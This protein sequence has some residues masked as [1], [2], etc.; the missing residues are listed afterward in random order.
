MFSLLE[1]VFIEVHNRL[2]RHDS[3]SPLQGF[4]LGRLVID[5]RVTDRW[6]YIPLHILEAGCFSLGVPGV[7]KTSL[8]KHVLVEGVHR[9]WGL[10]V[11]IAHSDVLPFFLG[12]VA[13][14]ERRRGRDLS[15]NMCLFNLPDREYA[16][17]LNF[18][19]A[20]DQHEL[21]VLAAE[22]AE[23]IRVRF[24]LDSLGVRI[25]EL[26]R[27]AVFVLAATGNT[28]V[29]FRL[30]LN[31]G[32]YREGL[33]RHINNPE[34]L[35]YFREHYDRLSVAEQAMYSAAVLNKIGDLVADP[36]IAD[37]IGQRRS[38][39]SL[40]H[41]L[42]NGFWL[43]YNADKAVLR[44]QCT[45]LLALLFVR[46]KNELFS[47]RSSRLSIVVADEV[48]NLLVHES[49]VDTVLSEARKTHTA[50]FTANQNLQ[51]LTPGV[52][53]ALLGSGTQCFFR[54]SPPDAD[55]ISGFLGGGKHLA[56]RLRSLP[57][58][59][60]LVRS[61]NER[62]AEVVV[63]DIPELSLDTTDLYNRC[64]RRWARPRAEVEAEIRQRHSQ[65]TRTANNALDNWE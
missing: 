8:L 64:M 29:E 47:R 48:Q 63:P 59:H 12:A 26:L 52:R 23:M 3:P 57:Q 49:G 46:L 25:M 15:G 58:R 5:G 9:N 11:L 30:F 24:D 16:T 1:H 43:A 33:L 36:L 56:E 62:I 27:N 19:E 31:N 14:E 61:G 35:G 40:R 22:I 6:F 39:V 21:F 34:I 65:F 7:G 53:A 41:A 17:G 32:A 37:S 55:T 18:I 51:Q 54:L 4:R 28:L 42:D 50:L 38:A 10:V 20:A 45:T 44:E 2:R 13:Q 60:M